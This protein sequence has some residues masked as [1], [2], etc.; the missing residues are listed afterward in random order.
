MQV[1][2]TAAVKDGAM[3]QA[4]DI[5]L[6][7]LFGM[8][9]KDWKR[10]FGGALLC[11]ALAFG[12]ATLVAPTFTARTTFLPP[13]QA[14]SS[15]AAAALSSLGALGA[16]AGGVGMKTPA[17]QYASLALSR[18]VSDQIIEQFELMKV[19]EETLRDDVRKELGE[20]VRVLIGKKD[21]LITIEVDD[22]SPDRA[23]KMA[24]AYVERLRALADT[25]AV[26]EAQQRR[27]F[28]EQQLAMTRDRLTQ[29]QVAL[30]GSGY[31]QGV[32]KAEPKAAAELYARLRAE[33][34]AATVKL[35]TMG[36]MLT[37]RAPELQQQRALVQ[38]LR[39]QIASVEQK[40]EQPGG[41]TE[42][43]AERDAGYIGKYREFKYQETLF[44]LFARQYEMARVDEAREGGLIQVLDA[45]VV[46]ER[47][48]KPKRGLLAAGAAVV[49]AVLLAVWSVVSQI[50]S[51]LRRARSV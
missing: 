4:I 26:T 41:G 42:A 1:N 44:E 9:A 40:S 36:S 49:A 10:V 32:L 31:S 33:L 47:K 38:A 12:G 2:T 37:D 46:P 11:G 5:G 45:A 20:N 23:A 51:A 30:Q 15:G 39:G 35:E 13:Q 34:T 3:R 8:V 48:S 29:A 24:N 17:D 22:K 6:L 27:R 14:Q 7:D 19:Y 43:G 50:G 21:G 16:L 28:F 25:L 18:T